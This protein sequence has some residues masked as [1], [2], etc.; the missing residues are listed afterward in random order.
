MDR[1][2]L[3]QLLGTKLSFSRDHGRD[4]RGV[5]GGVIW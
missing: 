5:K 1:D 4:G 2:A 3:E